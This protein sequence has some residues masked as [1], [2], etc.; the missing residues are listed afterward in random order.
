MLLASFVANG[1]NAY[2]WETTGLAM[3]LPFAPEEALI[4]E[5]DDVLNIYSSGLDIEFTLLPK[6]TAQQHFLY[7]HSGVIEAVAGALALVV[8]SD[9]D[10]FPLIREG[11]WVKAKDTALFTDSL[12]LGVLSHP[13][14]NILVVVTIDCYDA[15]MVKAVELVRSLFFL[16]SAA[17]K[18]EE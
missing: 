18:P 12:V 5:K 9:T 13:T 2:V 16:S 8:V 1:Q 17:T 15:P 6:D 14:R 3:Q 10:T 4:T 7:L 11:L